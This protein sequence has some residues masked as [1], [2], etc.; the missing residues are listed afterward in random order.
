MA[1]KCAAHWRQLVIRRRQL[2]GSVKTS[3]AVAPDVSIKPS[4]NTTVKPQPSTSYGPLL[5]R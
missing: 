4:F 2:A 5:A 1:L 3:A